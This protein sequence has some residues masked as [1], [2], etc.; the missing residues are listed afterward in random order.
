MPPEKSKTNK[1]KEK[2]LSKKDIEMK[3]FVERSTGKVSVRDDELLETYDADDY[4]G[5]EYDEYVITDRDAGIKEHYR[6]VFRETEK[7]IIN[8]YCP[9]CDRYFPGSDYLADQI[10]DDK[11]LWVANMVTHYRHEHITS[12][13]K[14]WGKNGN[15]YMANW[16]GE[17]E[18]EKKKINERAKC[19]IIRKCNEYMN[20]FSIGIEHLKQLQNN[21][22]KTLEVAEKLLNTRTCN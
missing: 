2:A 15:S 1:E 8:I 3:Y 5:T 22:V 17:Y 12:W 9:I 18:L 21:D 7:E 16:F 14:C 6:K 11:V 13:N 10:K 20:N 4:I 19:Q